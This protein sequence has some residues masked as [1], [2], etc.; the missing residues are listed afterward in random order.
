MSMTLSQMTLN[1][2]GLVLAA[3]LIAPAIALAAPAPATSPFTQAKI[4]DMSGDVSIIP[5]NTATK[6]PAKLQELFKAPDTLETGRRSH[7]EL[8]ADDGTIA[9]VGS[10]TAFSLEANS[11]TI[12]LQQGSILFN[13]PKGMGGGTIVTNS[14]TATVLG[15]TII[16]AATNN[17]GFK[18]LVLEGHASVSFPGGQVLNLGPGQMTFVMPGSSGGSSSG[19]SSSGGSSS[20]SSSTASNSGGSSSGGGGSTGGSTGGTP[21]PVLNFDLS[22]QTSGS[23]LINGFTVTL[24]SQGLVVDAT[25]AQQ[26]QIGSGQLSQTNQAVIGAVSG[27]QVILVDSD[28]LTTAT[29]T[30]PGN[31]NNENSGLGGSPLTQ[32]LQSSVSFTDGSTFPSTNVFTTPQS[33]S[34]SSFG[35]PNGLIKNNI[36][37]V[38]GVIAGD[39]AVGGNVDLTQLDGLPEVDFLAA[40]SHTFTF[41]S[42]TTFSGLNSTSKLALY[43]AGSFVF[44]ANAFIYLYPTDIN[45]D[46]ND[47]ENPFNDFEDFHIV[48]FEIGSIGAMNIQGATIENFTGNIELDTL[49]GDLSINGTHVVAGLDFEDDD[50]NSEVQLDSRKGSISITGNSVLLADDNGEIRVEAGKDVTIQDSM[51]QLAGSMNGNLTISAFGNV[52]MTNTT[53]RGSNAFITGGASASLTGG[54]YTNTTNFNIGA[55]TVNIN[56]LDFSGSSSV[57]LWSANGVVHQVTN[58]SPAVMGD[59]NFIGNVT[60]GGSDAMGFID[61]GILLGITADNAGVQ[62][63]LTQSFSLPAASIPDN[64]AFGQVLFTPANLANYVTDYN[65]GP[66]IFPGGLIVGNLSLSGSVVVDGNYALARN[67]NLAGSANV[68]VLS[69][70]AFGLYVLNTLSS[71]TNATLTLNFPNLAEEEE[72]EGDF[73]ITSFN[74]LSLSHVSINNPFGLITLTGF[75]SNDPAISLDTVS[76]MGNVGVNVVSEGDGSIVIASSSLTSGDFGQ[77]SINTT[78]NNAGI[79]ITSSSISSNESLNIFAGS[80]SENGANGPINIQSSQLSTALG[81]L[82]LNGGDI[83]VTN[84]LLSAPSGS[85]FLDSG[86]GGAINIVS[87][88]VS[89]SDE[90][91]VDTS[92]SSGNN[93][94]GD[95]LIQSSNITGTSNTSSSVDISG[96]ATVAVVGNSTVSAQTSMSLSGDAVTVQDSVLKSGTDSNGTSGFIAINGGHVVTIVNSRIVAQTVDLNAEDVAG[97]TLNV[98]SL[99]LSTAM[100]ISM[101]ARTISLSNVNFAANSIVNLSSQN[102]MLAPN[103]NTNAVPQVGFVNFVTNVLYGGQPAQNFVSTSVGGSSSNPSAPIR[104]FQISSR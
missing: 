58:L 32:A 87:S 6:S 91:S 52:T 93:T 88:T 8:K 20:S 100:A 25:H 47:E 92:L 83:A 86:S 80:F 37:K 99:D 16:V 67:V 10:N 64:L 78:N 23:N 18:I 95:V 34:A 33:F 40:N 12:H 1:R 48:D 29:Q 55:A 36:L 65:P 103:P 72:E 19:G 9:R 38:T 21:G 102:G 96:G 45:N 46:F 101:S 5:Y 62:S 71:A 104:I 22:R 11:R 89:A 79:S 17:G 56:N 76:L 70:A 39:I 7:A 30:N 53:L 94:F 4:N 41:S 85:V 66:F 59:I 61:E 42:N 50:S 63:A 49:L 44:P 97:S 31:G 74:S 77:I 3:L 35:I 82:N 68:T 54:S 26:V 27:N 90:I 43:S 57:N 75:E 51:L 60:Y 81:T 28:T 73:S 2:R 14:A 15:T 13:S 98:N 69:T 84:S 24:P